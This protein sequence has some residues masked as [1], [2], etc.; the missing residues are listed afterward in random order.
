MFT[1]AIIGADGAGKSTVCKE[2]QKIDKLP[3][4]YIY[5][6]VSSTSSNYSLP[7]TRL[8]ATIKS[9]LGKTPSKAGPP[10][11]SKQRKSRQKGLIKQFVWELK[12]CLRYS[13]WMSEEW[14]RQVLVWYY[15]W[16][17]SIPLFDRHFFIDFYA[18]D[19]AK[20][21]HYRSIASR[22]HGLTLKYLYP[23][24][25][26]VIFLDAPPELLFKRKGEG[27][28]ELL[29]GRREEYLN[30]QKLFE[31]FAIV[32]ASQPLDDVI[33]DVFELIHNHYLSTK[34]KSV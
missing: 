8:I 18:Y 9:R 24:P 30:M 22:V 13:T 23:K 14:Y 17:G 7:T 3:F 6:G 33:K 11:P 21:N 2:V 20:T 16:Q 29:K 1:L 28:V 19:I 31:H 25:D 34:K 5:M 27:T 4:K 12:A 15:K 32:D 10:D 26:M